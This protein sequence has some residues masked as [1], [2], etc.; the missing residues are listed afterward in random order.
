MATLSAVSNGRTQRAFGSQIY[1]G[2]EIDGCLSFL[3]KLNKTAVSAEAIRP[4]VSSLAVT[5]RLVTYKNIFSAH[6]D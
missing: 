3:T 6:L 1:A 4:S 2:F 5:F